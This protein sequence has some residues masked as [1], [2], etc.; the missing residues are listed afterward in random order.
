MRKTTRR[1]L[2]AAAGA[3]AL[4]LWAAW[5]GQATGSV[6]QRFIARGPHSPA[7]VTAE[8]GVRVY[9]PARLGANGLRHPVLTWG[10]GSWATPDYYGRLLEHLAGWGFV[11][12]AAEETFTGT[13]EEIL[14]AA[15]HVLA[16]NDDPR[17]DLHN[18]LDPRRVAA[19]GHSQGAG[20]AVN[21]TV[22]GRGLITA[23]ATVALPDEFWIWVPEHRISPQSVRV[24]T[25]LIG[26]STD[27]V[28]APPQTQRRY[29][30]R[31][32]GPAA[33]GILTGADHDEVAD[34]GGR[35]RGYLT[36]WLRYQLLSD[37]R[38][39]TAFTGPAELLTNPAWR[40]QATKRL[41]AP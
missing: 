41:R 28:M 19:A 12:A 15:R 29:Y 23:L 16:L 14:A 31:V 2:L 6:E 11:V 39:A 1:G 37:S 17:S 9:R 10:N 30:D 25:F 36:A 26:G 35:Y 13:G 8:D 5:P 18:R 27:Y 33:L 22:N 32:A 24:P 20:G 34:D 7:T 40:D 3:G 21:A 4:G 38:A